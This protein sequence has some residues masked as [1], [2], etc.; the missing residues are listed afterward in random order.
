[1]AFSDSDFR[2]SYHK[3]LRP[4]PRPF[5]NPAFTVIGRSKIVTRLTDSLREIEDLVL[6]DSGAL[7]MALPFTALLVVFFA[8][9]AVIHDQH[10]F[11][12]VT[13]A[14]LKMSGPMQ[15]SSYYLANGVL[16]MI[17]DNVFVATVYMTQTAE[18]FASGR[19]SRAQFEGLAIE[20]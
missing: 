14:V 6:G 5:T 13:D 11:T 9:V 10:L 20:P 8:I 4:S 18:A 3:D 16:S 19:I 17:S 2:M 7:T 12:P 15:L 1:M